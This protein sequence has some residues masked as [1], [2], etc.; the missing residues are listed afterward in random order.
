[1][2][3][4]DFKPNWI[5]IFGKPAIDGVVMVIA[6]KITYYLVNMLALNAFSELSAG[7]LATVAAVAVGGLTFGLMLFV[8]GTLT[9][10]DMD[11]MPGGSK[12]KKLAG[13]L[14][15]RKAV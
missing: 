1:M 7:R 6:V 11:M 14:S 3:A 15:L 5:K 2:K 10:E 9:E 13:K 4:V 12:L 8:T